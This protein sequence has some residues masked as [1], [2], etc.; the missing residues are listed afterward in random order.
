MALPRILVSPNRRFLMTEAGKPFFWL[1][2]TAWELFHRLTLAEAERY[3]EVRRQQGFNV[4]QAVALAELDGLHTPNAQG[5]VPLC[6][7]DPTRPNEFYFRHVD[8]IIRLAAEK[9]LYIGLLPTWGDKVHAQLWGIGPV[10]FNADNAR[11][12]GRF[13]GE[14]Y[15]DDTNVLWILGGDRPAAGY[16]HVWAA[17]AAGIAEGLGRTPFITYHPMGGQ[18]SSAWLHEAEWLSMNM[19]QSGHTSMDA[20]NWEM[21]RADYERTPT[22]PVLDGEPNYEHHPV[23]PYRRTWQPEYGRFTDY[24]VRKQAYRAVFAGA[25]GHTYGSHSVW[26]MW[27]PRYAPTTFASPAWDEA[28]YGPGA[29]QLAHLKRLMLSRPYF[30]RIPAP[31]LLP[32]VA[33]V[34]LQVEQGDRINPQRAAHPVATRDS[35]GGYALVYFPLAEQTLAVDLRLLRDRARSS[36]FDPRNGKVHPIGEYARE[37]TVFTSPIAGPDWVLVLEAD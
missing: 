4:I 19:L 6:G 37:L 5:H 21:I 17:M 15:R 31:D 35:D 8:A 24:D 25:C 3:F 23:D 13:L 12:Y 10:I 28:I 30:T 9:G 16:E 1:G 18:S 11:V 2:D 36:W 22:K 33:R 32:E 29:R 7:D 27:S 26:Q 34:P 14:R 20:P